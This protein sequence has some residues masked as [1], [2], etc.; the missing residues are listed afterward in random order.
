M[1]EQDI[2]NAI[3]EIRY[4]TNI[5]KEIV[6]FLQKAATD[7]IAADEWMDEEYGKLCTDYRDMESAAKI[8]D[9][10]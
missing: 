5:S 6:D 4:T 9:K 2:L 7:Q 1:K 8:S 3:E 10:T